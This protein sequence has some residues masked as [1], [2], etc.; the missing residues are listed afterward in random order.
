MAHIEAPESLKQ[1]LRLPYKILMGPGPSNCY[2]RVLHAVGHQ[3]LGHMHPEVFQVMDDIKDGLR[4]VFQT[5]NSLTLALSTSGHGAMEAVFANILEDG[6]RVLIAING[7]WGE[8]AADMAQR[9][10]GV[11][12]K[13]TKSLGNN[14]SLYD[15]EEAV[16]R[17]QPKLFFIT[18]GES[19]TGVYQPLEGIGRICHKYNCLVGVDTVA[20]LGGVPLATDSWE[21]DIVY[22]G[23]QKVL[24]AP[25]G[26][27]PITFSPRAEAVIKN[28]KSPCKVFYLDMK[29]L[30]QQWNCFDT[31]RPYHHTTCSNLLNGLREGLA[32]IAEE[33][34]DNV[35]KRHQKCAERLYAGLRKLNLELFVEN[36][37]NR[38]P[39]VT[40]IKVPNGVDWR[41]VIAYAM[42]NYKLEMSGGLGPTVG[43]I[44]RVGIMGYNARPE[45]VDLVLKVLEEADRKSVV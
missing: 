20:S 29:I 30:G 41:E 39:T 38:L 25:P 11:V 17:I 27:A 22:T 9:Y 19:S 2:P 16:K 35:L 12:F 31:P 15:I 7:L 37:E 44:F 33:G 26:L 34:L 14:F 45:N 13:M 4:Y 10:G 5:K 18:Q 21:I 32:I 3:V 24:G 1:P 42:K 43:K 8:R 6:D 40:S 36:P 28:R 23:S